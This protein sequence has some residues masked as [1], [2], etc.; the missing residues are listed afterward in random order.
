MRK[1]GHIPR[2]NTYNSPGH[3]RGSSMEAHHNRS[4]NCDFSLVI[5][6]SSGLVSPSK[7]IYLNL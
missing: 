2:G 1:V 7:E 6:T 5:E 3:V 4:G